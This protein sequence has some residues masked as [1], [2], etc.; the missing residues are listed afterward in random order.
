MMSIPSSSRSC[1]TLTLSWR[2]KVTPLV[3]EP[4]LSVVSRSST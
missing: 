4:S 3:W 2:V 1:A